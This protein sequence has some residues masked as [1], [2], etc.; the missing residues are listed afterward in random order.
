MSSSTSVLSSP[1]RCAF[2]LLVAWACHQFAYLE[3]ALAHGD[4][5]ASRT[6][7]VVAIIALSALVASIVGF[8]FCALAGSAFAYMHLDPVEAVRTMVM[9][10]TAIQLYAVWKIRGAIRWSALWA[11][12]LAG[13]AMVPLGVWLLLHVAG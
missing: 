5:Q 6:L 10:S 9:C 13:T 3:T 12:L 2:A 1:T 8:A 4:A 7:V 11:M